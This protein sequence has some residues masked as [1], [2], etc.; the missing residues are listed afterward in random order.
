MQ[1]TII[2]CFNHQKHIMP[3]WWDFFFKAHYMILKLVKD[4]AAFLMH[5]KLSIS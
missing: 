5:F 3:Q 1:S 4:T 2:I